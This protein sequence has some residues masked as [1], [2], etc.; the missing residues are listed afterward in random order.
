MYH[1]AFVNHI[2]VRITMLVI[3][4]EIRLGLSVIGVSHYYLWTEQ[5]YHV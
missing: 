1:K 5:T 3:D 2:G 4:A